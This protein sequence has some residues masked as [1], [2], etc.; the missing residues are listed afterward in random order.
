MQQLIEETA[1]DSLSIIIYGNKADK[2]APLEREHLL[3]ELALT[4]EYGAKIFRDRAELAK[5]IIG[6]IE[7]ALSG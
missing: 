1:S 4:N 3:F 2:L 7:K 6:I 5:K